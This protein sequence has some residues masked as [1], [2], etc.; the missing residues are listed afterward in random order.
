MPPFVFLIQ[1]QTCSAEKNT[2]EKNVEIMTPPF[3]VSSFATGDNVFL[4]SG[5][6]LNICG[7]YDLFLLI[8]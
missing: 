7:R 2:L 6:N 1:L 8:T 5:R 4:I 3:K